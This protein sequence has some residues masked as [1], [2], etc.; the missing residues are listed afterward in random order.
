M[1]FW[2]TNRESIK[3]TEGVYYSRAFESKEEA[4]EYATDYNKRWKEEQITSVQEVSLNQEAVLSSLTS[5]FCKGPWGWYDVVSKL[6]KN[7]AP[8][9][10]FHETISSEYFPL[11]NKNV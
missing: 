9:V 11:E 7:K 3:D 2:I 8:G 4:I 10:S 6:I 1:R 5:L